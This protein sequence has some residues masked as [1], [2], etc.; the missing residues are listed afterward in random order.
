[1]LRNTAMFCVLAGLAASVHAQSQLYGVTFGGTLIHIDKLTGAGELVGNSG[2]TCNAAA[3]DPAGHILIGGGSGAAAD[4]IIALDPLTGAGS[5]FLN[6]TGR[7]VGYGIRGMAVSG[8]VLYVTLSQASTSTVDTLARIDMTTGVYTVIGPTGRTDI[9]GLAISPTGVLYA[10]GISG[11]L[12]TLDSS[13]GAA[14]VIGGTFSGDDQA[15]EF[16]TDGTLFCARDSLRTVNL[17]SGATTLIGVI[18]FTDLRGLAMVVGPIS[19][20]YPNCDASTSPP[21]LNVNDFTCFLNAFAAGNTYANCDQSTAPPVLNVND[22][23]CFL[24][25]FAA[26]CP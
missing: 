4:Q 3:A 23:T 25:V 11:G 9:Q 1:M 24:N 12:Y 7:P 15:L 26:G 6:T 10:A 18:G 14:T 16:D 8:S 21:I 13:T 2:L 5:V 20:C 19:L 17:A 22:F